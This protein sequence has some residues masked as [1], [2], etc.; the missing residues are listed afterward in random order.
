MAVDKQKRRELKEAYKKKKTIGGVYAVVNTATGRALL[1]STPDIEGIQKRF[2][3]AYKTGM[4]FHPK[5]QKDTQ[6][7][8]AGAFSFSVIETLEKKEMETDREFRDDLETL[9]SLWRE[10][11]AA[12][13]L[14]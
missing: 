2:E 9:L 1:M 3:F 13:G 10:K 8:G 12:E 5:L 6:Q 14:Y 4:Y 11:Y 7:Y